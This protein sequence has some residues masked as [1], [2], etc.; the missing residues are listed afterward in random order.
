MFDLI[1]KDTFP[2]CN[3]GETQL[4]ET[5]NALH[6]YSYMYQKQLGWRDAY[7]QYRKFV[8]GDKQHSQQETHFLDEMNMIEQYVESFEKPT[9]IELWN[10]WKRTVTNGSRL[11]NLKRPC[12][13]NKT[14]GFI[15]V[16]SKQE[17]NLD[18]ITIVEMP[19][20]P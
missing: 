5:V 17:C 7:E 15:S 3:H 14:K 20:T 13:F 12:I 19:I 11:H 8:I 10:I 18:K 4:L 9:F 2:W 1:F 6:E 16:H